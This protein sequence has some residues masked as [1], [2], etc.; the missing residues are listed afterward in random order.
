M[1]TTLL[2]SHP[3]GAKLAQLF[4][5][6]WNWI[7]APNEGNRPNWKTQDR[8]PIKPRT[9][10]ARWQ[11]AAT[12]VGVRFGSSTCYGMLD[13]DADSPYNSPEQIAEIKWALETIG[14]T[15][16]ITI[17]S[18]WSNG[19]HLYLPLPQNFPTWGVAVALEQCLQCHGF[20]IKPGQLELFPNTKSY[21]KPWEGEYTDY[22]A[23]RLPLQ[24]A[25][26]S[27]MLDDDLN[28][29]PNADSLAVFLARWDNATAANDVQTIGEA[30]ATARANRR[31]RRR[32]T[33]GK[34]ESWKADL[35]QVIAEGWTGH[36]QTNHL[37][38]EIACYGRVFLHL[39]GQALVDHIE[40]TATNAPGFF[41]WSDHQNELPKRARQWAKSAEA[42]Y[43]PLGTTPL[44]ERTTLSHNEYL[45]TTARERITEAMKEIGDAVGLG[46]RALAQ[47]IVELTQCSMATLYRHRDLWHPNGTATTTTAPQNEPPPPPDE[48]PVTPQPEGVSGDM[49]GILAIIR[50]SLR[51]AG[52]QG[53]THHPPHN[54]VCNLKSAFQKNLPPGG[55]EGG[56]GG[57]KGFPQPRPVEN[58]PGLY[59]PP[60]PGWK[61]GAVA[62]V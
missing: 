9:L 34:I 12:I 20:D 33:N 47:R 13:I 18:S 39:E 1:S 31:R 8:F 5:Y 7:E 25:T 40:R 3:H 4:S 55:R 16:T 43:W 2:P 44:R 26:G 32:Q 60:G 10:W 36:G 52:N 50:E 22:N 62:D 42:F 45:A 54:E 27:M 49:A 57:E 41:E 11:D 15:R 6:G 17:R 14:I 46:I 35:E 23:H 21:A 59:W 28:P 53:V 51:T 37:L 48:Q 58:S 30:I 24:P 61:E 38:K 19:I 56:V 29:I